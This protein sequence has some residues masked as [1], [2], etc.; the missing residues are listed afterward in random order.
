MT[1]ATDLCLSV[2][3]MQS[4]LS[5]HFLNLCILI[6]FHYLRLYH[7]RRGS[8]NIL[9]FTAFPLVIHAPSIQSLLINFLKASKENL[10]PCLFYSV[11]YFR[12]MIN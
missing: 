3:R 9:C 7:R 4:I 10:E 1:V 6:H 2:G 8:P 11:M 5:P 12:K